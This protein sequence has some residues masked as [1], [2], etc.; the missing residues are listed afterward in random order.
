MGII[1][2][3]RIGRATAKLA[4]AFGMKVVAHSRRQIDPLASRGFQWLSVEEVFAQSDFVSLHCPQTPETSGFVN[5]ELIARMKPTAV[6][7]N[8]ARG[9]LINEQDLANSL[10]SDQIAGAL[11]DVVSVEP[12]EDSNPLLLA[13]N[14]VLTPHIAW[15]PIESR[16]R[17]MQATADNIE[18]FIAGHP[19]NLVN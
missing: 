12:I 3:G 5:S 7:I 16:R 2:L 1:G 4:D 13:K 15:S 19:I 11:L 6:L 10:N 9:G 18:A 17:L 14:C 8:T